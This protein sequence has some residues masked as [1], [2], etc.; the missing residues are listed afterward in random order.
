MEQG[1][2]TLSTLMQR[3]KAQTE[4]LM[5]LLRRLRAELGEE[6]ANAL[7]YPALRDYSKNGPRRLHL[8]SPRTRLRIFIRRP[9][10][11]RLWLKMTF[12]G[13]S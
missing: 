9:T 5:P 12:T 10:H 7:V 1:V 13:I 4:V 2:K 11:S 6:K 3:V 8:R